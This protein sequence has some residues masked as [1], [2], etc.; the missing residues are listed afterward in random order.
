MR[1][2]PSAEKCRWLMGS[3]LSLKILPTRIDRITLS[4]SFIVPDMVSFRPFLAGL[5]QEWSN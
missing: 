2:A 3:L 1:A 5:L 4:T